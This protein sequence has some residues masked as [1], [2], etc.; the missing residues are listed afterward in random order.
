MRKLL[1]ACAVMISVSL[2]TTAYAQMQCGP[3]K[4]ITDQLKQ[5]FHESSGGLGLSNGI[6]FEIWAAPDTGTF[7]ILTTT[8]RN[9]SCIVAAGKNW[10]FRQLTSRESGHEF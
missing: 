5:K 9:I 4:F 2:T 7:T 3:R 6:L 8:P 10:S 1:L